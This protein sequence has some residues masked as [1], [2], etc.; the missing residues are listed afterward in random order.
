[1]WEKKTE[2]RLHQMN[3]WLSAFSHSEPLGS[4]SPGRLHA[5]ESPTGSNEQLVLLH[6]PLICSLITLSCFL[7]IGC[8]RVALPSAR[9]LRFNTLLNLLLPYKAFRR[10]RFP[11]LAL[12]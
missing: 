2:P 10:Y 6:T 8:I 3:D 12:L 4:I 1:M 11:T 5:G 7:A 9:F